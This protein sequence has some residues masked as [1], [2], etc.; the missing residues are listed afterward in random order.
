MGIRRDSFA[1]ASQFAHQG[2]AIKLASV[3]WPQLVACA[4][5]LLLGALSIWM[6]SAVRA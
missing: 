3:I 1:P 4:V 6:L 2:H 5:L